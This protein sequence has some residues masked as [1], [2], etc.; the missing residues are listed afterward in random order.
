[1]DFSG[2]RGLIG[3]AIHLRNFCSLCTVDGLAS[4]GRN[5]RCT[6]FFE[7]LLVGN[8]YCRLGQAGSVRVGRSKTIIKNLGNH[9]LGAVSKKNV[10][11]WKPER[12]WLIGGLDR[13]LDRVRVVGSKNEEIVFDYFCSSSYQPIFVKIG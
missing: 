12:F 4:C 8:G 6:I 5:S 3:T 13:F 10:F 9:F 7:N 1:M 2:Q 11:S